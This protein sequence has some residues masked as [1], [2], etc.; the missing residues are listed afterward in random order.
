MGFETVRHTGYPQDKCA[1]YKAYHLVS[2]FV[3]RRLTFHVLS[4]ALETRLCTGSRVECVIYVTV[5]TGARY[6]TPVPYK[7]VRS[8]HA[9]VMP[10]VP[11]SII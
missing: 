1:I 3:S 6:A 9:I 11:M 7:N 4:H 8:G 2:R 5:C 10:G